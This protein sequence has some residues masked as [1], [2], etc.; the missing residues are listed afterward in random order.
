MIS[1]KGV[2]M[3]SRAK[4][5]GRASGALCGALTGLV[6]GLAAGYAAMIPFFLVADLLA[7]DVDAWRGMSLVLWLSAL[8]T[9]LGGIGG[10]H[11]RALFSLARKG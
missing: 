9:V 7:Y 10:S 3:P 5:S 1:I 2:T 6:Y 4:I 11:P 8:G